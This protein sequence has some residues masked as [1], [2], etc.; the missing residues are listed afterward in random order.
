M[1]FGASLFSEPTPRW[2]VTLTFGGG[3]TG[4]ARDTPLAQ[5]S[6]LI[7]SEL[8]VHVASESVTSNIAILTVYVVSMM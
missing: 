1:G 7:A 2:F 3:A 6:H 8:Q 5:I 4:R